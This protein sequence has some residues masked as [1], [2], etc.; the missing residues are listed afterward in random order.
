MLSVT[1]L[2]DFS[3]RR[4]CSQEVREKFQTHAEYF[5]LGLCFEYFT[6]QGFIFVYKESGESSRVKTIVSEMVFEVL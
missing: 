1:C 6:S 2:S 3:T 5:C 4:T